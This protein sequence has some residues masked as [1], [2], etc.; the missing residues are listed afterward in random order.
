MENNSLITIIVPCYNQA[1][2]L[3]ESLQSV[4]EQTYKNWECV[5]VNDG[6]PD[7]TEEIAL[8]WVKRD[9]RFKYFLKQN[10]GVSTARNFGIEQ[11]DGDFIQF[12]DADD[13]LD[14]KKLEFSL[15]LIKKF[16]DHNIK[17]VISDFRMFINNSSKTSAP[18]CSLNNQLLNF[19]SLLYF[20]NATFSIPIHCGLFEASLF[21]SIRFPE[22]MTAQEDWVV[23]VS[24]YKTGCKSIFLDE[25]LAFYRI[26]PSG[27]TKTMSLYEDQLKAFEYLRNIVSEEEFYQLSVILISRYYKKNDY[28][29]DKLNAVK[30]SSS[31]Q[32]GLMIKKVLK[33]LGV[34]TV[35]KGLFP[36][37]LKFKS[38]KFKS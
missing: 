36:V 12:L 30:N 37:F 27:R 29:K 32:T 34:L 23:W 3:G 10:G 38:K 18:Y 21:E 9:S 8:N 11:S 22:D 26:N 16:S 31:Y 19:E 35:S 14:K 15:E 4:F 7:N 13:I 2:H 28:L 1:Q 6:S 20:W 5:I 25:A 33:I 24:I 17:I